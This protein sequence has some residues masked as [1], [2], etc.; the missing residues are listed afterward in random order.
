MPTGQAELQQVLPSGKLSSGL[1]AR[2]RGPGLVGIGSRRSLH[3]AGHW[4]PG[5]APSQ[6]TPASALNAASF[7]PGGVA[8]DGARS[9]PSHSHQ[10]AC[11]TEIAPGQGAKLKLGCAGGRLEYNARRN[12]KRL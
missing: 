8:V 4:N 5:N 3:G 2:V 10:G 1:P 12:T 7:N 11:T 6:A 9:P